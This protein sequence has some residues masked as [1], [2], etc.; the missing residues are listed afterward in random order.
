VRLFAVLKH[1][2]NLCKGARS[3]QLLIPGAQCGRKHDV[4]VFAGGKGHGMAPTDTWYVAA[5]TRVEGS[6]EG[7]ALEVAKQEFASLLPLLKPAK[8]LL[9]EV[10]P[11]HEPKDDGTES[12]L[13]V[14]A[15]PDETTHFDSTQDEVEELFERI[16]GEPI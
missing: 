2:P 1:P 5:S 4:Y 14:C 13:F 6:S 16:L 12:N 3:C 15:S 7:S 9:A 8:K 10:V 11:Y